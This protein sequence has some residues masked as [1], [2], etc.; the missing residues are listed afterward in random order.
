MPEFDSIELSGSQPFS[1]DKT[2]SCGQ[3]PRCFKEGDWWYCTVRDSVFKIKQEDNVLT[4]DGVDADI[5]RDYFCL[6]FDLNKVYDV[7]TRDL[8]GREAVEK[9]YGLRLVNQ[10]T[11]ECL[12]FQMTV[13][14]IRTKGVTDRITR[15]SAKLG[16]KIDFDGREFHTIPRPQDIVDAGLPALKSCNIGYFADN[17][18][19]ASERILENPG[20]EDE[21]SKLPYDDAVNRLKEFKGVKHRVAEWILLLSQKRYEAF[22]VDAHIRDIFLKI[23]LKG[24]YF[25]VSD[26]KIDNLIRETAEKNF[27][28]YRGYALEYFFNARDLFKNE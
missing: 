15:I 1:L 19:L 11:W 22:P 24:T 17:I 10:D 21:L 8:F 28:N 20:W 25:G 13:N 26:E 27:E 9:N 5:I 12:I 14:R 2:L 16:E 18:M 6:D 4:F 23:Y 3:V 7:M